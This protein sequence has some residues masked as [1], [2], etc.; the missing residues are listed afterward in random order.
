MEQTLV[1]FNGKFGYVPYKAILTGDHSNTK[2]QVTIDYDVMY[3]KFLCLSYRQDFVFNDSSLTNFIKVLEL[4]PQE[5]DESKRI[6]VVMSNCLRNVP[7]STFIEFAT[8]AN[9]RI[10]LDIKDLTVFLLPGFWEYRSRPDFDQ[11]VA[12]ANHL[13]TILTSELV[14]KLDVE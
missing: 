8:I 12:E 13:R 4:L 10:N 5:P 14:Y 6:T 9:L 7:F 11:K 3:S 2:K 1:S